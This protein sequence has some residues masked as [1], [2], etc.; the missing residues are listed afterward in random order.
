MPFEQF[1]KY[2]D[3]HTICYYNGGYKYSVKNYCSKPS[4]DTTVKFRIETPGVYYFSIHQV[5]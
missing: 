2:Y 1:L 5:N 3:D 4:E